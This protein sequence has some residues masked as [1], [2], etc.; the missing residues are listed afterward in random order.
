M[1]AAS[2]AG[3][4]VV[5]VTPNPAI[6]QTV[7]IPGFRA[8][9]VNR[10]VR[11]ERSA[12]GKGVNVASALARFG[13]PVAA[14]GLLGTENAALFAAFLAEERIGDAFVRV[15]GSTRTGVKISDPEAGTTTDI[16]FPG[17]AIAPDALAALEAAVADAVV[18]GRW[19]VLA[20]S[21]PR[22]V[23][24]TVYRDLAR[25]VHERGGLV[26]LDSSGPA[27]AAALGEAPELIKPNREELEELTGRD[28]ADRDAVIAAARVLVDA[29]VETVVVS[30]G[31]DGALFVR[32]GEAVFAAPPP[33]TV[34]STVGAGDAMVAGTLAGLLRGLELDEVA[35]LA[36]AFSA[37]TVT[38]VGPHLDPDAVRETAKSVSVQR[39]GGGRRPTY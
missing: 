8:G 24:D 37:V 33:V 11:E 35:A 12:G 18:P 21:L 31:A 20:G 29:G 27:L 22:G 17:L 28:L 13:V 10:V 4:E 16:N 25:V 1:I 34:A 32:A 39:L 15:P 5:T 3:V 23:P 38:R 36:T 6:D 30:L 9:A 26:A 14:T 2:V 19:I 7:W